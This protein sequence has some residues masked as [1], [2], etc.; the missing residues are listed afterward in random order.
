MY[1][2]KKT[3]TSWG[4]LTDGK[5]WILIKK[6]ALWNQAHQYRSWNAP[7]K[8]RRHCIFYNIFAARTHESVAENHRTGTDRAYRYPEKK[9][10]YNPAL[11][12]KRTNF[13]E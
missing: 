10:R 8:P 6:P 9:N 7:S 1:L 2:L 11:S 3:K 12:K 13:P 5:H 4:I